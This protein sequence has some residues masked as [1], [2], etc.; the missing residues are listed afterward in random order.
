[1]LYPAPIVTER[2][3]KLPVYLLTAGEQHNQETRDRPKGVPFYHLFFVLEGEMLLRTPV[4]ENCYPAGT[5][6]LLPS[7]Y[8]T[9]YSAAHGHLISGWLTFNGPCVDNL[10]SYFQLS[11]VQ[12]ASAEPLMPQYLRCVRAVKYGQSHE[13]LSALFYP[14]LL[15][16]FAQLFPKSTHLSRAQAFINAHLTQDLSVADI[17]E[18]VGISQSLLF[19]LFEKEGLT[20][21]GYLHICRI[22]AAKR[23]L[24]ETQDPVSQI[25][26]DCGFHDRAYFCKIFRRLVGVSPLTFRNNYR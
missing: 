8:P 21:I 20:P 18:A 16:F 25:G 19:R 11:G 15:D 12:A 22:E 23:R 4:G 24:L 10:L 26:A 3:A 9:Y 6:L 17:A 13:Q 2:I 5:V 7:N 1:M 14:L